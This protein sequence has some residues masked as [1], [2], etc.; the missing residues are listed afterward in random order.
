MGTVAYEVGGS[1]ERETT[2]KLGHAHTLVPG[3]YRPK[4]FGLVHGLISL[5]GL[6][7]KI[8]FIN[9]DREHLFCFKVVLK[10]IFQLKK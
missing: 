8:F 4:C 5:L 9:H 1:W 3:G 6:F 2:R 10:R 7:V